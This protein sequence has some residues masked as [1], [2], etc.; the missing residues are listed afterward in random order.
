MFNRLSGF[1]IKR[2][3]LVFVVSI[4]VMIAALLLAS[5]IGMDSKMEG[6][7]PSD[8]E[9]LKATMEYDR[10]FDSQ[11]SVMVVVQGEPKQCEGYLDEL[12]HKIISE[13]I[14][15][16]ILYKVEMDSMEDSLH[17]YI[18]SKHYRQL[19]EELN[20]AASPLSS[21][22]RHKDFISLSTL[23]EERLKQSGEGS[24]ESLLNHFAKLLFSSTQLSEAEKEEL[25]SS[26]LFGEAIGAEQGNE[27]IASMDGDTYLMVIKPRIGMDSFME[28]RTVFFNSLQAAMEEVKGTGG[29][30]VEAGITGGAFVQDNE[31]DNTM[32][33][34]FF[35]TALLTFAIIILFIVLSFRRALLP[36][37]AGYPLILGAILATAF[38]YLTYRNLNIFSIS[39][40]VLL[41]G[42]GI[43]FAVH[44]LSRYL[45]EREAGHE[46]KEAVSTTIRETSS[47]MLV[48]AIT[49]AIAFLTF[50]TAEF[51]AFTQ[52]GVI[53]G[54]GILLLGITM[55]FVM[56][57]IILLLD[58]RKSRKSGG[59]KGYRVLLAVG[60]IVEK[61]AIAVVVVMGI[62][63]VS[64]LGN[65]LS[66]DVK[67]DMSKIYPQSMECLSWLKTVEEEFDFNP[68]TLTFM[69]DDLEALEYAASKLRGRSDIK[70][71]NSI[72][73]Y[74]PKEQDYKIRVIKRFNSEVSEAGPQGVALAPSQ[75][76]NAL[77]GI[78]EAAA[79]CN[80]DQTSEGYVV[81]A[82]VLDRLNSDKAAAVFASMAE[83][84]GLLKKLYLDKLLLNEEAVTLVRLPESV[85]ASFVGK[86]GKL[87]IE[88]VPN[89]N[90]WEKESLDELSGAIKAV[91]GR[92]PVGMPAIMNEVTA[93]AKQDILKISA[94]CF[95]ALFVILFILFRSLRDT[96][97]ILVSLL[98]TILMTVGVM[99]ILGIDLNIFSIIAFPVLIGIG[100]DSGVHLLHRINHSPDK[101]IS[102]VLAHTGKAV[103]MT[104]MTTLI[105]FGSLSFV[106]H[107]G[108]ASFGITTVVGM[109]LCLVLTMTL[110]PAVHI[111]FTKTRAKTINTKEYTS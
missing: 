57:A 60:R 109:L 108:L 94:L 65:V 2:Y 18:D 17:L 88:V 89:V 24:S 22:I 56:P 55:V 100:V 12:F 63:V 95:A 72:L 82:Q 16:N 14:A 37:A 84:Q 9:S 64:L 97:A 47:G 38:A 90:I 78:K 50:L 52:M 23:F 61:K 45:E 81:I 107:P 31:A 25:F 51:K 20:N 67:T 91:S 41:L 62:I 69:V 34:G 6:M 103:T 49:T 74:L 87:S 7:L 92:T 36:L 71:L 77:Q 21:F 80:V 39:F 83:K 46:V 30:N 4:V 40:A 102:Y 70:K 19:E 111:L 76:I 27:Y 93:Y 73:E 85:K 35:S 42:L 13:G 99:P 105:G 3:K 106:N 68:N 43:D 66:I 1:I 86:E 11:D 98:L 28:D 96:A 26:L 58:S 8:S 54:V 110:L 29:Y 48:G 104:T 15:S 32:F 53:S 79:E 75:L 10:Y 59:Y 44:I 33:N 101:D 5:N